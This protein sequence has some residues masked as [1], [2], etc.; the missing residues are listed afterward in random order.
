MLI[1]ATATGIL[2]QVSTNCTLIVNVIVA[3]LISLSICVGKVQI[4]V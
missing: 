4:L 2:L 3:E 1:L